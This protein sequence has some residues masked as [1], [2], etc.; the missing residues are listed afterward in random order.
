MMRGGAAAQ[1]QVLHQERPTFWESSMMG[2]GHVEGGPDSGAWLDHRLMLSAA[3]AII[4]ALRPARRCDS[5]SPHAVA[6]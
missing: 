4:Q 6:A 5:P 1:R 3:A 2:G